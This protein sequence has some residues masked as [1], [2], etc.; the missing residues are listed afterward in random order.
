MS[1]PSIDVITGVVPTS[2]FQSR[3]ATYIDQAEK[4]QRPIV[5]TRNGVAAGVLVA[6]ELWQRAVA[7]MEA[8][9]RT[10]GVAR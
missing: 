6:P 3:I 4:T 2:E 8:L 1:I 7:A 5:V 10:E 9:E